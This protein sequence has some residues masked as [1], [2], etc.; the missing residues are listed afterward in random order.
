MTGTGR[1]DIWQGR[2]LRARAEAEQGTDA[3]ISEAIHALPQTR[4]LPDGTGDE[5]ERHLV[6]PT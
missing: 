2:Q 3:P 5:V 1:T 6:A 4:R